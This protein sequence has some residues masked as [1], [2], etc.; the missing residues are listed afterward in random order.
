M[1]LLR[2]VVRVTSLDD[3]S[4]KAV[5]W[6]VGISSTSARFEE[7]R[8]RMQLL[9]EPNRAPAGF[10]SPQQAE[11]DRQPPEWRAFC[12]D[13]GQVR[14]VYDRLVRRN[15]LQRGDVERF[16]HYLFDCLLGSD[17]N[18]IVLAA[19]AHGADGIELA[20]LWDSSDKILNR[21][22]WELLH[23]G[24]AFLVGGVGSQSR[25]LG[26]AI[27]R[28]VST[29]QNRSK[30]PRVPPRVLFVVG[31]WVSDPSIRPGTEYLG[32][33]R[34]L[35]PTLRSQPLGETDRFNLHMRLLENPTLS[36]VHEVVREFAPDLVHF[37][38][39]GNVD[40]NGEGYLE[41]A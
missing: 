34:H 23:D 36:Q 22:N 14:Q 19:E 18:D 40:Q 26:V 29:S 13:V 38:C 17:W 9:P 4:G 41:L 2:F 25:K 21:L 3:G 35:R 12:T 37:V 8:R 31:T 30:E 16:G 32:Y 39:H 10:P 15:N 28:Q 20:L 6:D 27:T 5:G 24:T 1:N 33:L 11:L 7:R